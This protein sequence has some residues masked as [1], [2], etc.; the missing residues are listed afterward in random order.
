MVYD[1]NFNIYVVKRFCDDIYIPE[2]FIPINCDDNN[3]DN[4]S[5]MHNYCELRAQY[6][7]WKNCNTINHDDYIGFFHYRRYLD[8]FKNVIPSNVKHRCAPYTIRD[9]PRYIDSII[10]DNSYD[11]IA[12]IKEYIGTSVY[13]NYASNHYK[14]DIDNILDIIYESYNDY[15]C[16]AMQYM[17]AEYEYYCNMYIMKYNYFISYCKW[18]FG[19][20]EKFDNVD[21]NKHDKVNGFLGERLFGIYFT[22]MKQREDVLC[23]ELPREHFYCYDDNMHYLKRQILINCLLKPGSKIRGKIKY[24]KG[25]LCNGKK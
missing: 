12:P 10:I 17:N 2:C 15:Y 6:Y 8:I 19:I 21:K 9:Y 5:N 25:K 4:I 14:E 23:G 24:I 22:F 11:I 16:S 20:L 1:S 7:I 18:L 13:E 3:G